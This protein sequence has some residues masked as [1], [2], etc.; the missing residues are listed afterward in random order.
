MIDK[1]HDSIFHSR[2][3]GSYRWSDEKPKQENKLQEKGVANFL[4]R[5]RHLQFY[6]G[7]IFGSFNGWIT[8]LFACRDKGT[9]HWAAWHIH[10]DKWWRSK[11]IKAF[12]C[13]DICFAYLPRIDQVWVT[14]KS[15]ESRDS[16]LERWLTRTANLGLFFWP[17]NLHPGN[18]LTDNIFDT[19]SDWLLRQSLF[20]DTSLPV[21]SFFVLPRLMTHLLSPSLPT[22]HGTIIHPLFSWFVGNKKKTTL[23]WRLSF[24]LT[25]PLKKQPHL[26]H[27][28]W[29]SDLTV[30]SGSLD[31]SE[32]AQWLGFHT[33]TSSCDLIDPFTEIVVVTLSHR[34]HTALQFKSLS[35][36]RDDNHFWLANRLKQVKF[37]P[38]SENLHKT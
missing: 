5:T 3:N 34:K 30:L 38:V 16:Q 6:R 17:W 14:T 32:S 8:I 13:L 36:Q 35:N 37:W 15:R 7:K 33:K 12:H 18:P 9:A 21:S 4:D 26:S 24:E 10:F 28:K 1:N 27:A 31:G 2:T 11:E 19:E 25:I 29:W 22:L 23:L 20:Q